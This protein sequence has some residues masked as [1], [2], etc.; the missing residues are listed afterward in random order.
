M[1]VFVCFFAERAVRINK[2]PEGKKGADRS[3]P[4]RC[5]EFNAS[6]YRPDIRFEAVRKLACVSRWQRY[7]QMGLAAVR[8]GE[9]SNLRV[10]GN[11]LADKLGVLS[12]L[13][14]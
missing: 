1:L 14:P 9:E 12:E 2:V 3:P 10:I 6:H 13:W 11:R 8:T 5:S 7:V 4:D